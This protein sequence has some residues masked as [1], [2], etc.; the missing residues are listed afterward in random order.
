MQTHNLSLDPRHIGVC[1]GQSPDCVGSLVLE[2]GGL[3]WEGAT[4][5]ELPTPRLSNTALR[6][7]LANPAGQPSICLL[8]L[9]EKYMKMCI[10]LSL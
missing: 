2:V 1:I 9:R 7:K 8:R 4:N 5:I 3:P 10:Q 6:L